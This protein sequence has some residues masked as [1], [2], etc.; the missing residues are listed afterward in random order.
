MSIRLRRRP[1]LL[2][3]GVADED[4]DEV[5][6]VGEAEGAGEVGLLPRPRLGAVLLRQQ[7][8]DDHRPVDA[9]CP[10]ARARRRL[11]RKILRRQRYVV[12]VTF[13]LSPKIGADARLV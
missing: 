9:R 2:V 7:R 6:L 12:S 11:S 8:G 1:R 3:D 13:S 4:V 10:R 5:L